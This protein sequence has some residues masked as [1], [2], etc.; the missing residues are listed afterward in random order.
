[1]G[2]FNT[3]SAGAVTGV[4]ESGSTSVLIGRSP[5]TPV[6]GGASFTLTPDGGLA[7]SLASLRASEGRNAG[8][9]SRFGSDGI[10]VLGTLIGGGTIS[11]VLTFDGI[12]SDNP[13]TDFQ[14]FALA[15]FGAVSAVQF[16]AFGRQD[17][18][19]S[20]GFDD[21]VVGEAVAPIPLPAGLPLLLAGLCGLA[22]L[23][24]RRA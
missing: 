10:T 5:A 7:F 1:M 20:F 22:L 3:Y 15:G 6:P 24:R 18:G 14:T 23:R 12:A 19:Y 2:T 13:A 8:S 17:G 9:F 4:P 21:I 16:T 11:Q